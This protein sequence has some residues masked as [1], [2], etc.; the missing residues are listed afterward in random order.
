MNGKHSQRTISLGTMAFTAILCAGLAAYGNEPPVA[1]A[2]LPRYAATDPVTL[3]GTGSYEPDDSGPLTYAWRQISGPP[4]VIT[5]ADTA[6]PTISAFVQTEVIQEC[7]FELVVS[8]QELTSPGDTTTVIVV[9]VFGN[10]IMVL[11][12]NTFDA[13]KPTFIW[14]DGAVG[15]DLS[16]GGGGWANKLWEEKA[17]IISFRYHADP[18]S[19]TGWGAGPNMTFSRCADQIIVFLSNAAPNYCQPIQTAGLS[20]GGVPA[21]DV[22]LRLNQVYGDARYAI[23]H[24][25]FLDATVGVLGAEEYARRVAAF[26]ASPVGEEQCWLDSYW[27]AYGGFYPSALNVMFTSSDHVLAT[28]W[29]H[30]SLSTPESYDFNGGVV[31]GAYWSVIGPGKNLQLASTPDAQIYNFAWD[32]DAYSGHMS[33]HWESV[34]QGRLPEPV[35]LVAWIDPS[36]ARDDANGISLTCLESENA[37]GYQ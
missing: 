19:S 23:N 18:G 29:Y 25:T 2:G 4:L 6:T 13:D 10:N 16:T 34:Y 8:D 9:P 30:A 5:G 32:G 35:T 15:N 12:N 20:L 14:F 37:V 33:F 36:F 28:R 31:A 24:V 21:I 3:D 17:N 11:E 22:A 7:V 27:S 26:L 1:D